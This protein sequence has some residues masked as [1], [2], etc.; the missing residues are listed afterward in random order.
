MQA[1]NIFIKN[2]VHDLAIYVFP[3]WLFAVLPV[4]YII[5]RIRKGRI[6]KL[7]RQVWERLS[8]PVFF[9]IFVIIVI[10]VTSPYPFFRYM[11]PTIPPL[12]LLTAVIINAAWSASAYRCGDGGFAGYYQPDEGLS[13]RNYP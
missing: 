1:L 4:W 9:I 7:G 8:L 3:V 10:T 5:A 13:L 11:A 12:I 6:S 2:Y